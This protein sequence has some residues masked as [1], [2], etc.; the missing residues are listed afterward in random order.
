MNVI[1]GTHKSEKEMLLVAVK[2]S[3]R[4]TYRICFTNELNCGRRFAFLRNV[5]WR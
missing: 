3:W 2:L 4:E 5:V 1:L